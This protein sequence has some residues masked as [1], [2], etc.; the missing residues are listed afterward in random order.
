[1]KTFPMPKMYGAVTV[2]ERGQVV[3]PA[4]IR[5]LFGL[6]SGEKLI[7]FAKPGGPIGFIPADQFTRFLEQATQLL[8]KVKKGSSHSG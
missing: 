4:Q 3:I 2:G 7:V 5:K 1:M 8:T 6:K